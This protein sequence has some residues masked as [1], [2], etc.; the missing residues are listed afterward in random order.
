MIKLKNINQKNLELSQVVSANSKRETTIEISFPK[1][2]DFGGSLPSSEFF[3]K[4]INQNKSLYKSDSPSLTLLYTKYL[5][6]KDIPVEQLNTSLSLFS[7][8]YIKR[9]KDYV[10]EISKEKQ[11]DLPIKVSELLTEV[12]KILNSFRDLEIKDE[13]VQYN[14]EKIDFLLSFE[15]EQFLLKMVNLLQKVKG[16]SDLRTII[17]TLAE[18]E[19]IYRI[20]KNYHS[21]DGDFHLVKENDD[22]FIRILN[23]IEMRKRLIELPLK[24]SEKVLTY[25]KKEK[26]ISLALATGFIMFI[27]SF[28]LLQARLLGIDMTLQ[29]VV[30]LAILYICRDLFREEIKEIIYNKIISKRPKIKSFIYVPNNEDPVGMTQT[31]F[32]KED[33]TQLLQ[34]NYK[35]R[36]VLKLRE[37]IKLN[38]FEHHGFKRMRTFT[39]FD[40]SPLLSMIER[41][42]RKLFIYSDD[43][44][45][46]K[47]FKLP[48]QYQI[49]LTVKETVSKKRKY[50][51][52]KEDIKEKE[53]KFLIIINREKI[54]SIKEK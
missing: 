40:L 1:T 31:W 27:V 24:V 26:Y 47:S 35:D 25:G 7:H 44:R 32:F 34:A 30:G 45:T 10:S 53:K 8:Q 9:L 11:E 16:T 41:D 5:E 2:L 20:D 48:R 37:K 49:N 13:K 38:N 46:A 14:F 6:K 22:K 15:T 23:K 39:N 51:Q 52:L 42:G 36:V 29:F 21:D 18:S 3:N 54:V 50:F 33:K 12:Q 17:I 19:G 4:N 28:I 43:N